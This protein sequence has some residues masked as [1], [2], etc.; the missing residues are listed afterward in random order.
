MAQGS[1]RMAIV[2]C[3]GRGREF[4]KGL[5]ADGR[6]EVVALVDPAPGRADELNREHGF[7]AR[8]YRDLE[9]MLDEQKPDGVCLALWTRLH[10]PAIER[11]LAAGARIVLCEKPMAET[12]G[13]CRRIAELA[14][15]SG[16]VLTFCHQRRFAPGNLYLRGLLRQGVFGEPLRMDLYSP[17]HLLDCGTHTVDQALSFLNERPARWVLGGCDLSKTVNY[18]DVPA[19]GA[20]VGV[21]VFEKGVRAQL[22]FG[23]PDLDLWGGVRL[24][25]TKGFFEATWDGDIQRAVVYDEPDWRPQAPTTGHDETMRR[26]VADALDAA[27]RGTEPELGWRKALR[28][29]E[30][31][32]ALYESMRRRERV[33]LPLTGVDDN[34][35]FD[36]LGLE[37]E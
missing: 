8:A 16:A 20:A 14:E 3:G 6:C 7:G 22:Q 2:G 36:L 37:Q 35:M 34:R 12:W 32:F 18:F 19:E 4:A 1:V 15:R 5:A 29:S 26:V 13:K 28:A 24:H 11:C 21:I 23:G 31:L 17:P 10:L 25:G 9:A 33:E 30:I 27:E